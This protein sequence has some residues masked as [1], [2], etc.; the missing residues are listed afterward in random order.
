MLAGAR[1]TVPHCMPSSC[2]SLP[3]LAVS[4]E[5]ASETKKADDGG[6]LGSL[7]SAA[8]SAGCGLVGSGSSCWGGG[9]VAVVAPASPAIGPGWQGT[10]MAD[11]APKKEPQP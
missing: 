5:E 4:T 6:K 2:F 7:M 1:S 8:C 11:G 10:A 3:L 9:K